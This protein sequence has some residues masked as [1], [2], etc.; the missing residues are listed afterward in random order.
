MSKVKEYGSDYITARSLQNFMSDRFSYSDY[1][2]YA[3]KLSQTKKVSS[4]FQLN[5]GLFK[6]GRKKK[7]EETFKSEL[8]SSQKVVYGE[9]NLLLKNSSFNLQA[10][11]G[12]RKFYSRECLSTVFLRNLYSSTIGNI[13]DT[14][15]GFVLTGYVT[16]GKACA[17]YTGLSRSGSNS[18]SKETGMEKSIDASFSWK[19]N[20]ASGDFQF[21]KGNFNY[22][23]SE[24]NM[25]QLFT[26]MWVYGGD[27][28]GLNMNSAQDLTS[29]NFDLSP[30]VASLSD[31]K[32][33]TIIDITENGLYPLSAFII[34]EN[35]KK[36]MDDTSAGILEKYPSF[37]EPHIEIMRVFERYG[38]SNEALYDVV[39]VLFTRQGDRII[40]RS[41]NTVTDTELRRNE[42]VTVF[43][44][45]AVEIK[46]Q[47]QAFYGLRIS[48]NSVT[49][50]N[51]NLGKPLCINLPKVDEST[52]Y[53][54]TNPRTGIQYIYDTVNK[55]AFSHYTDDLD[56]DWILD[57]YGIRDWIEA[58]PTK[59]ISMATL[60]NS[61]RIIGL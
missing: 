37:V 41:G 3:S 42:N 46:E 59:S 15:G 53:T 33:H 19:N 16:G 28:A 55:I 1:D 11:D 51:P 61:Y 20:S 57:D 44:Q 6:L 2:S 26:K 60:A 8:T 50:L 12:S 24:Y 29:I 21:G 35:F 31:S 23:S 48:S 52:M 34:E 22:T 54:Y 45:K 9:L 18:T 25:E 13:M 4:G 40:L 14:Y 27:P 5:L 10:S 32:K 56:G 49:R 47:K 43:N 36:R 30:W 7:T 39:P 17:L 58:L 38:S